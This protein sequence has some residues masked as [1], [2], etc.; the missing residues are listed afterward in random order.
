LG[1]N[2]IIKFPNVDWH[3]QFMMYSIGSLHIQQNFGILYT[4]QIP[5]TWNSNLDC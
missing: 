3:L 1:G 2:D 4:F 5:H